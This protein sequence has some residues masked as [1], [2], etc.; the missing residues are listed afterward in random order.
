M[1]PAKDVAMQVRYRFASVRSV[2]EDQPVAI[3]L[4]AEF[5]GDFRG[6]QHQVTE[7]LVVFGFG[8]SDAW[9]GFLRNDQNMRRRLRFDVAKGDNGIVLIDNG[10]RDLT[11]DDFF[12]QGFAHG[13]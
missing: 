11:S 5:I 10:G 8:F 2:V 6:L 3:L 1:P 9:N 13:S 7:H 12:K 4:E